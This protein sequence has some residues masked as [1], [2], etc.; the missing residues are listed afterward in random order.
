M[1]TEA[2]RSSR[3]D[4]ELRRTLVAVA[5]AEIKLR[6]RP[7]TRTVVAAIAAFAL[8]G[9]LSGGAVSAIANTISHQP[10]EIER[11]HA[12][13]QSAV[14]ARGQ[15]LGSPLSFSGVGNTVLD[16]GSAPA[17]AN[18]IA[19]GFVCIDRAQVSVTEES[20]GVFGGTC[21]GT[22]GQELPVTGAGKHSVKISYPSGKR[23]AVSASWVS[24]PPP[25]RA[26]CGASSRNV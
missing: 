7:A 11:A 19:I 9:A 21:D 8:A 20:S 6:I 10:S 15:L 23:Y 25:P 4:T 5:N 16:L 24:K 17:G 1:S 26:I 13:V 2:P 18:E 12:V 14:G 22:W 3:R